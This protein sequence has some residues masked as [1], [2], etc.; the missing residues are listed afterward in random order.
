MTIP[1][2]IFSLDKCVAE[3]L[4]KFRKQNIITVEWDAYERSLR[5]L[6]TKIVNGDTIVGICVTSRGDF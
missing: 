5:R 3:I 1:V 6:A 4:L 2:E